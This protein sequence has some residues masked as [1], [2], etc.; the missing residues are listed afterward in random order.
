VTVNLVERSLGPSLPSAETLTETKIVIENTINPPD[1]EI[2]PITVPFHPG[3]IDHYLPIQDPYVVHLFLRGG[4][5]GELAS[6]VLMELDVPEKATNREIREGLRKV[7]EKYLKL[8]RIRVKP[9][10]GILEEHGLDKGKKMIKKAYLRE[11]LLDME[12]DEKGRPIP[13]RSLY[14]DQEGK[15]IRNLVVVPGHGDVSFQTQELTTT[16][17][18]LLASIYRA[19]CRFAERT[20]GNTQLIRTCRKETEQLESY[21]EPQ[22]TDDTNQT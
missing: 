21:I 1:Q 20:G 17:I 2:E 12:A 11:M 6:Q 22:P 8:I 14:Q 5:S 4:I 16:H 18:A 19:A 13:V 7:A 3:R 10:L 15:Q 9:L